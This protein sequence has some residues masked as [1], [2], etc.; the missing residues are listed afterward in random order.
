MIYAGNEAGDEG[1]I[2]STVTLNNTQKDYTVCCG[3]Y[4]MD[5]NQNTTLVCNDESENVVPDWLCEIHG[6]LVV[7]QRFLNEVKDL[8]NGN[9]QYL[10]VKIDAVQAQMQD[11]KYYVANVIKVIDVIDYDNSDYFQM[12]DYRAV[13]KYALKRNAI[14][15]NHIFIAKED[16]ISNSVFV[17]EKVKKA[18]ENANLLGFCL[19]PVKIV[20]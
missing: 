12:P 9:I 19:T 6:W 13:A 14:G 16:I 20:D 5:W 4:V 11:E 8:E 7:S 1:H 2:G 17:S 3:K 10:P 15:D 18:I